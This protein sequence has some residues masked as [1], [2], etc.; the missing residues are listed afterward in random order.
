MNA[1]KMI[2]GECSVCTDARTGVVVRQVTSHASIHHHPF[3]YLPAYDDAMNLLFLV[4]HRTGRPEVF[5]EL[6]TGTGVGSLVQITD[7]EGLC[8]WS[9]HPSPEG[10]WV[11]FTDKVG[12]WRARTDG[13]KKECLAQFATESMR[14]AGMVGSA[15]GT[16][17]LSRCGTWWAVPVR[18]GAV[19]RLSIINTRTG[20]H[21]VILEAPDIG[22]PEFHPLDAQ[23]LRYAGSYK[24]RIWVT[25]RD[26]QQHRL[27]FERDARRKQWIVHETWNPTP[28]PGVAMEIL[29]ADWPHG[30]LGIDV[31]TG[32][33]RRVTDFN[34]W[35]PS[36][37]RDGTRMIADTVFPDIGLQLFDPRP[38]MSR[39]MTL[40]HPQAS[41]RG[42]HWAVGHCPYDDGPIKVYA[43]QHTHPH[44]GFS[45]DGK[46][47]VFTSDRSG[48]AQVYEVRLPSDWT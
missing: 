1:G 10:Q 15:M 2:T 7:H 25:W 20:E 16:T 22:H 29:T 19:S 12:A 14:G 31:Q 5:A 42:D 48:Q 46:R 30:V 3:Y 44:P 23:W 6:Q 36:V 24:Q 9:V 37:S 26:G 27:V 8:E 47:V 38:G 13:T 43:P 39:R 41:S 35:H 11:Y 18:Y 33:A 28:P 45:P 4:S 34:A 17:A 32:K 21:Q 40:C